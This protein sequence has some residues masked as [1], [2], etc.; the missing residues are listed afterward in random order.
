[1]NKEEIKS[2]ENEEKIEQEVEQTE[3]KEEKEKTE[4]QEEKV[5]E[6]KEKKE[7]NK[8]ENNDETEKESKVPEKGTEF[9]PIEPKKSK[10]KVIILSIIIGVFLLFLL[11]FSVIFALINVNNTKIM[12]GITIKGIDVSNLTEEEAK[13]K[14]EEAL[15]LDLEKTIS[16]RY[17][18]FETSLTPAQIEAKYQIE[19]AVKQAYQI[20][21]SGNVI[22]DNYSIFWALVTNKEIEPVLTYNE[23]S[24]NTMIEDIGKKIPGAVEEGTYSIEGEQLIITKGKAGIGIKKEE[25]ENEIIQTIKLPLKEYIEIPVEHREP[26]AIN[27]DEIYA[28]VYVQPQDAY[29]ETNPH[30]VYPHVVGIDFA[31]SL[32]EAR[33]LLEQD[34]EEYIIPLK[35]TMPEKTTDMLEIEAF[36]DLLSTFS[37]KYDVYLRDRTTNLELSASKINGT[38]LMPGEI[39]SYNKVVGKRTVEAGYKN[40]A[41]YE[42]GRVVDGLGGGICQI[43]S[44]LYNTALLANLEIIERSNHQFLTSYVGAGRDATVVYGYIDFQFKNTRNYPIKI[45]CSV[46]N[47]IA[48]FDM[49]GIKEEVE[50][51][52]EFD[53]V[54]TGSIPYTT[55]YEEDSTLESGVEKVIQ[56]GAPGQTSITYKILKLNGNEVSR[57][58]L[59][60]DTYSAMTRI[61]KRGTKGEKVVETTPEPEVPPTPTPSPSPSPSPSPTPTPTPSPSPTPTPTP[62]PEQ[63]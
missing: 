51:Q 49:Y 23:E 3:I 14:I 35:F 10:K 33:A 13:T 5:E 21:R 50:Y 16:L 34:L 25:L 17:A 6:E 46:E 15:K 4:F 60:K 1:M 47:G 39:F 19:E 55:Q 45:V 43:S 32:E 37:T 22:L 58:V 38:V 24:L 26:E 52:V 18:D 41:V 62:T 12:E 59:S 2:Q 31:I 63:P 27:I 42:G 30:K 61:I 7:K 56:G 40:A 28:E 57:E 36:P 8:I 11:V 9:K 20:G 29:Y 48:K 44:T 53:T 54:I